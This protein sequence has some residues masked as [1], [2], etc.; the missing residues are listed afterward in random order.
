[1]KC[2][3]EFEYLVFGSNGDVSCPDCNTKKVQRLMSACSFKSSGD[4]SSSSASSGCSS[5][6]GGSCSTCH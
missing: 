5:C 2:K 1:M 3:K 4:F 6:A